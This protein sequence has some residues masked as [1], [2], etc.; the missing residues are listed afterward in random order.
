MMSADAKPKFLVT[1]GQNSSDFKPIVLPERYQQIPTGPEKPIQKKKTASHKKKKRK[2]DPKAP[3]KPL[4]AYI[5]FCSANWERIRRENPKANFGEIGA[6]VGKAWAE[7]SDEDRM[8]FAQQEMLDRQQYE[9]D[10][11]RYNRRR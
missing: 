2:I 6:L 4:G 5:R 1:S 11:E 9:V 7:T 3:K 8:P 10:I